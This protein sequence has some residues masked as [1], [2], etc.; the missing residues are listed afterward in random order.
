MLHKAFEPLPVNVALRRHKPERPHT[1]LTEEQFV[2]LQNHLPVQRQRWEQVYNTRDHG[3]N[4]EILKR[5]CQD[6][7][8]TNKSLADGFVLIAAPKPPPLEQHLL[9][10]SS[11]GL[12]ESAESSPYQIGNVSGNNFGDTRT[13]SAFA[14]WI[15]AKNDQRVMGAYFPMSPFADDRFKKYYGTEGVFVFRSP[16]A[17]EV[18]GGTAAP[19]TVLTVPPTKEEAGEDAAL[20]RGNNYFI[21][22]GDDELFVGGGGNGPMMRITND[23][24]LGQS[25]VQ[26]DTFGVKARRG[27]LLDPAWSNG[28][29]PGE[30]PIS[31]V[32]ECGV[33]E[34]ELHCVELWALRRDAGF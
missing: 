16:S 30:F 33:A 24:R 14:R 10:E 8:S 17:A 25:A 2:T 3:S 22:H 1:S 28:D 26:C 9:S 6:Y 27:P 32:V 4:F 5:N 18:E 7:C 29:V 23:L 11:E 13:G 21:R 15:E 12:D 19:L 31:V 20:V 34:A